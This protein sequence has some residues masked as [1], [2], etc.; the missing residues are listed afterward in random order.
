MRVIAPR[1]NIN[2][3]PN[4][5]GNRQSAIKV[6]PNVETVPPAGWSDVSTRPFDAES[7][8]L[9]PC[10]VN[11]VVKGSN[12]AKNAFGNNPKNTHKHVSNAIP[13]SIGNDTSRA[14]RA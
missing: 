5:N 11:C 9:I 10:P 13:V 2:H 14:S 4:G 12:K 1:P 3:N 7:C 6:I 8:A